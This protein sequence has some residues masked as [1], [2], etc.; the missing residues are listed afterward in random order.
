[1]THQRN[2]FTPRLD[3][4]SYC[5]KDSQLALW[6]PPL[7]VVTPPFYSDF[8]LYLGDR[9]C[10][11]T[12]SR[13][14]DLSGFGYLLIVKIHSCTM[15]WNPPNLLLT[16]ISLYSSYLG[17]FLFQSAE[18]KSQL[19]DF[20]QEVCET[21]PH[22]WSCRRQCLDFVISCQGACL[23]DGWTQMRTFSMAIGD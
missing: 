4:R 22:D 9:L 3:S 12:W 23:K 11:K 7:I 15:I 5:W 14:P 17:T 20:C 1:M 2:R 8:K 21:I 10:W 18:P 16:P 19:Y 6:H 13:N